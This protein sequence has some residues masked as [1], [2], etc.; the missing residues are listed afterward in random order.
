M[1]RPP[2]FHRMMRKFWLRRSMWLP[3]FVLSYVIIAVVISSSGF[4]NLF[5]KKLF[6]YRRVNL[7]TNSEKILAN[8]PKNL[9]SAMD[10]TVPMSQVIFTPINSKKKCFKFE[11]ITPEIFDQELHKESSSLQQLQILL[12][13]ISESVLNNFSENNEEGELKDLMS[14]VEKVELFRDSIDVAVETIQRT[15]KV[16]PVNQCVFEG[17]NKKES[18]AMWRQAERRLRAKQSCERYDTLSPTDNHLNLYVHKPTGIRVCTPTQLG[19]LDW[20]QLVLKDIES[21]RKPFVRKMQNYSVENSILQRIE[22]FEMQSV[23]IDVRKE[24][25]WQRPLTIIVSM[26]PAIRLM[27]AYEYGIKSGYRKQDQVRW[28]EQIRGKNVSELLD[29]LKEQFSEKLQKKKGNK[30]LSRLFFVDDLE[31]LSIVAPN[32][33][34]TDQLS[35]REFTWVVIRDILLCTNDF[36]CLRNVDPLWRPQYV[37]CNPCKLPYDVLSKMDILSPESELLSK[38]IGKAEATGEI[39]KENV[40]VDENEFSQDPVL[41]FHKESSEDNV[42]N[43]SSEDISAQFERQMLKATPTSSAD[44]AFRKLESAKN[45][46]F[47]DFYNELLHLIVDQVFRQDVAS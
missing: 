27:L 24:L 1:H 41:N 45:Q 47:I 30:V 9:L 13:S 40:C 25:R 26:H 18:E 37:Q 21:Y 11:K 29:E 20:H 10:L 28:I 12:R 4:E 8:L 39:F 44:R 6:K 34:D 38:L 3:F 31:D 19:P 14:K 17:F 43:L 36:E 16:D 5:T 7:K 46:D 32:S 42:Q 35:F 2:F 23:E 22:D 15:A 33:T